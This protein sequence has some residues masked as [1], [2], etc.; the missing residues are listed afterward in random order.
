MLRYR[1]SIV[2][3]SAQSWRKWLLIQRQFRKPMELGVELNPSNP[4]RRV[5]H[6]WFVKAQVRDLRY[7]SGNLYPNYIIRHML[8]KWRWGVRMALKGL[9]IRSCV[10]SGLVSCIFTI[11]W[12]SIIFCC[13][14][15]MC[16]YWIAWGSAHV[17]QPEMWCVAS[18]LYSHMYVRL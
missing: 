7:N 2:E 14:L 17:P 5:I 16:Y 13:S 15:F 3:N 11:Q 12:I 4:W 8:T 10:S 18:Q 1:R 6:N 9:G